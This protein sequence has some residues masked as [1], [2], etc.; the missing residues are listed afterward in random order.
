MTV[1]ASEDDCKS[2]LGKRMQ[3]FRDERMSEF[4]IDE[5]IYDAEQLDQQLTEAQSEIERLSDQVTYLYNELDWSDTDS[6]ILE[7][8]VD[9]LV[10]E[11]KQIADAITSHCMVTECV[12]PNLKNV[13]ETIHNLITWHTQLQIDVANEAWETKIRAY[14]NEPEFNKIKAD[15]VREFV[16]YVSEK[17]GS[18]CIYVNDANEYADKL[19]S[20]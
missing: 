7:S 6:D 12:T 13:Y 14:P 17:H 4:L 18:E 9:E 3:S 10:T 8:R 15:A 5:F 19:E 11:N 2:A 1:Y 16:L 20:E